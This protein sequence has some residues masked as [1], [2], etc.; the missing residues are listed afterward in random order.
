MP[1][2][3][4]NK[5][6][7]RARI[8]TRR[9]VAGLTRH[10]APAAA[11][12]D[13]QLKEADR[14]A[15]GLEGSLTAS[16]T[17]IQTQ[18]DRYIAGQQAL[19]TDLAETSGARAVR[20]DAYNALRSSL[21]GVAGLLESAYGRET[22][23]DAQLSGKIPD[24]PDS[25]IASAESFLEATAGFTLP[26]PVS[27][28]VAFD[29]VAARAEVQEQV[30]AL[31]AALADVERELKEDQKAR[32]DR[33]ALYNDWEA[34]VRLGRDLATA[35]LIRVG[36]KELADRLLPS[37]RQIEGDAEIPESPE[38]DLDPEPVPEPVPEPS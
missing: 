23:I 13:A 25:L 10:A 38:D 11:E 35:V 34:E 14:P 24:S 3:T 33:N 18:L 27:R 26:E 21:I 8:I 19:S 30:V 5:T 9:V 2:E 7:R 4:L 22:R 17:L 28:F 32:L 12:L 16:A 31:S 29:F 6:R 37:D 15:L 20:D 1:N 36:Q